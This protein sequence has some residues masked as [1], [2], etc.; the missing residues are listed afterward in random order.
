MPKSIRASAR[1]A[2]TWSAAVAGI[3]GLG[4]AGACVT[5][6]NGPGP[7]DAGNPTFDGTVPGVDGAPP[8]SP[9]G[10]TPNDGGAPPP[11][12]CSDAAAGPL[13]LTCADFPGTDP[14]PNQA[15]LT[16]AT[17]F[18]ALQAAMKSGV[19]LH[20]DTPYNA[21]DNNIYKEKCGLE[22]YWDPTKATA[23]VPPAT[24]IPE[25]AAL[26]APSSDGNGGICASYTGSSASTDGFPAAGTYRVQ[27]QVAY[28]G[29]TY[30][31]RARAKVSGSAAGQ[32]FGAAGL[33]AGST[34]GLAGSLAYQV[35]GTA[36]AEPTL[37]TSIVS[38][39]ASPGASFPEATVTVAPSGGGAT[40]WTAVI[41]LLCASEKAAP[42]AGAGV[43][44]AQDT[45]SLGG[46]PGALTFNAGTKKAYVALTG[47]SDAGFT[48]SGGVAVIDDTTNAVTT[49][50]ATTNG[51][52]T[53]ASSATTS[54]VYASEQQAIAVID[55]T[56][57]TITTT[58][59]MPNNDSAEGMAVDEAA[60]VVYVLGGAHIYA[61]GANN[62]FGVTPRT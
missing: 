9:D 23:L 50:I 60:G 15:I 22:G 33:D 8:G 32:S 12:N 13:G 10:A 45:I 1:S 31:V 4:A 28:Q 11:V 3:A 49:T 57:D 62:T 55:S 39:F 25:I 27:F 42:A 52:V 5:S 46:S 58:V 26:L 20:A 18:A 36:A 54:T 35:N 59:S 48:V 61:L 44:T 41:D 6:Q 34:P 24:G 37:W 56:K 38:A 21:S 17:K 19:I 30:V 29:Q 53:M 40:M 2:V 43:V 16:D 47:R 14:C 51:V 7:I